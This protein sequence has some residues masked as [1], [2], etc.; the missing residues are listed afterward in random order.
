M[1]NKLLFNSALAAKGYTKDELAKKIG[2]SRSTLTRRMKTGIFGTDEVKKI[3]SV[4]E[5]K[6]PMPIFFAE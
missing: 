4:L 5:V 6:N 3:I 1:F 2:M